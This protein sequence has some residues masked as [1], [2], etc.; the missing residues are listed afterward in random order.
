M[1]RTPPRAGN[2]GPRRTVFCLAIQRMGRIAPS[3]VKLSV[4][5]P[6]RN[7]GPNIRP[8]LDALRTRLAREGIDYEL[9]VVDD[10]SSGHDRGRGAGAGRRRS[11]ACGW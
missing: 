11:A 4:V 8:T 6:A 10:G 3:P 7:E 9:V 5:I 1:Y 2:A